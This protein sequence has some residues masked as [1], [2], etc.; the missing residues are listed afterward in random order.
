M[1][2]SLGISFGLLFF[3][4]VILGCFGKSNQE[5]TT[6][7]QN[8]KLQYLDKLKQDYIIYLK[9]LN[10]KKLGLVDLEKYAKMSSSKKYLSKETIKNIFPD[11]NLEDSCDYF[12]QSV[13]R[14]NN[15]I[16][17]HFQ[18][19]NSLF[20]RD[21]LLLSE[22]STD[23]I[24]DELIFT[25][26]IKHDEKLFLISDLSFGRDGVILLYSEPRD[27][28]GPKFKHITG[29]NSL[30]NHEFVIKNNRFDRVILN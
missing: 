19:E 27:V 5:L 28:N 22:N 17:F 15:K 30:W 23:K 20:I 25:S 29:E 4:I 8:V 7:S 10:L 16:V 24:L 21:L 2:N 3:G 13:V 1:Q 12:L 11:H 18:F 9:S 6:T 26:A 14:I